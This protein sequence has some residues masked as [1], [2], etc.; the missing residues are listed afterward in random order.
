LTEAVV[1]TAD[2]RRFR[3]PADAESMFLDGFYLTG[4]KWRSTQTPATRKRSGTPS[5]G[6]LAI[7]GVGAVCD[8]PQVSVRVR[9]SFVPEPYVANTGIPRMVNRT[10]TQE[11]RTRPNWLP[12]AH[13]R[14]GS[15]ERGLATR[16]S[17]CRSGSPMARPEGG[18]AWSCV[19]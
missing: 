14:W 17:H 8:H 10:R 1:R 7:D 5:P 4:C 18:T 12:K 13:L 6:R 19:I 11:V 2:D 16:E 9:P 3:L 15:G